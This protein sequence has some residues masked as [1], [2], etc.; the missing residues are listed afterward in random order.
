[1]GMRYGDLSFRKKIQ[2][3]HVFGLGKEYGD[4]ISFFGEMYESLGMFSGNVERQRFMD[5]A[6]GISNLMHITL[7]S[8]TMDPMSYYSLIQKFKQDLGAAY[9]ETYNMGIDGSGNPKLIDP[10]RPQDLSGGL[11][12]GAQGVSFNPMRMMSSYKLNMFKQFLKMSKDIATTPKD[13]GLE[14][15]KE[16][17]IETEGGKWCK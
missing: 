2:E 6:S 7:E 5:A 9:G 3:R 8:G 13:G 11:L 14:W 16:W 1:M 15:E 17:K 4:N 10:S 12:G